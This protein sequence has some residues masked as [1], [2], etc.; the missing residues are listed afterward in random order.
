MFC[1]L[2]CVN[3]IALT[4]AV[5]ARPAATQKATVASMMYPT[6]A[7]PTAAT[8][9]AISVYRFI[10]IHCG[11]H[12]IVQKNFGT[13]DPLCR[14]SVWRKAYAGTIGLLARQVQTNNHLRDFFVL[15]LRFPSF[16]FATAYG[17]LAPP[18]RLIFFT[19]LSNFRS[20][21]PFFTPL[22]IVAVA[23]HEIL[24]AVK[25]T[26]SHRMAVSSWA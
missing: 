9:N 24:R 21:T 6:I 16:A 25:C 7:A 18:F 10:R 5:T 4:P 22:G 11:M 12:S 17:F 13:L 2:R 19:A 8:A 1:L 20:L 23:K 15:P 3:K 26:L 14:L